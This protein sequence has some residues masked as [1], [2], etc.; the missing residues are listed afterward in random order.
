MVVDLARERLNC[1]DASLS[2]RVQRGLLQQ[3]G[4]GPC[5]AYLGSTSLVGPHRQQM[6]LFK[7]KKNV[8][9]K[10]TRSVNNQDSAVQNWAEDRQLFAEFRWVR[11][12]IT[13]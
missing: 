11:A 2:L 8:V 6:K 1:S 3:R 12:Q 13:K 10:M 7:S 5:G 9:V 4:T